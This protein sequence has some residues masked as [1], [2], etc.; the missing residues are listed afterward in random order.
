MKNRMQ[1]LED[2][3]HRIRFQYTPKHCSWMNQI[4]NWFGVLQK[5][6]IKHGQFQSIDELEQKI[7]LFILYHNRLLAKPINWKFNGH[8]Y[9]LKLAT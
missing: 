1:F 4:E 5:K 9:I 6:V 8:K 7:E 2:K 3:S